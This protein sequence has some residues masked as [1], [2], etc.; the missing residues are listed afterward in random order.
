MGKK[1]EEKEREKMEVGKER[2]KRVGRNGKRKERSRRREGRKG[3]RGRGMGE[4]RRG[5]KKG[6]RGKRGRGSRF[7]P[8]KEIMKLRFQVTR[9][10]Y[11]VVVRFLTFFCFNKYPITCNHFKCCSTNYLLIGVE[12]FK[13]P[14]RDGVLGGGGLGGG[15]RPRRGCNQMKDNFSTRP[16][17]SITYS[18]SNMFARTPLV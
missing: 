18:P 2:G 14:D 10:V 7:K 4:E 1:E 5:R 12:L 11:M 13:E 8:S 17:Y 16:W 9:N 15:T 6:E 3:N